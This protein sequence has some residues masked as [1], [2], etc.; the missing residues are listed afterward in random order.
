MAEGSRRFPPSWRAEKIAGG[1]VLRD[2][3]G[4]ARHGGSS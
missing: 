4:Q 3:T 2:A 1:Y